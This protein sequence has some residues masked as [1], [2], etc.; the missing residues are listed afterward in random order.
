MID[1]G[2]CCLRVPDFRSVQTRHEKARRQLHA[3]GTSSSFHYSSPSGTYSGGP[4]TAGLQPAANIT[5]PK[6]AGS[7]IKRKG[8]RN[9]LDSGGGGGV[10]KISGLSPLNPKH[11]SGHSSGSTL[12]S[13]G[14]AVASMNGSVGFG[15][16][17]TSGSGRA[18]S[19]SAGRKRIL[20]G[21][22]RPGGA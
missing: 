1:P 4:T 15:V 6:S 21:M 14:G 9:S 19:P 12:V 20:G 18:T 17:P 7:T 10:S 3:E 22:R 13:I 5:A 16:A 2:S 11:G 8:G